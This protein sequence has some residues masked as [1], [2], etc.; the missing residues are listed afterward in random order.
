MYA[1]QATTYP[2][3]LV[4]VSM[5]DSGDITKCGCSYTKDEQFAAVKKEPFVDV[6]DECTSSKYMPLD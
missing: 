1:L 5:V 2:L 4:I 6:D 3:E